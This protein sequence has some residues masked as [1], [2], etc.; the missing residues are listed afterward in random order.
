MTLRRRTFVA[1]AAAASVVAGTLPVR[2]DERMPGEIIDT[3]QHLWDLD[4]FRLPWLIKGGDIGRTFDT[5]DYLAATKGL[6]M[7][8]VYMEVDVAEDQKDLE[9]EHLIALCKQPDQPT[10][11]AVIGCRPNS[12]KF[13]EYVRRYRDV[14]VI[15]GFRQVLSSGD[16]GS[17]FIKNL[18]LLGEIDKSFDLCLPG[19]HLDA[20]VKAVDACPDTRFILDHCGNPDGKV[21]L[22][23][24]ERTDEVARILND[25]KRN[26]EALAKR[27]RVI[28][29]IS[30]IVASAPQG[31]TAE[32][33]AP[34]INHCLDSFGPK[35]VVFGSDWP[36]CLK[37][38]TLAQ[39]VAALGEVIRDR[40]AEEQ[41]AL[42]SENARRHYALG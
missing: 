12:E 34:I 30:G 33:L 10:I 28:C 39:W 20:A 27:D 21:F 40:K 31:W 9:A 18:Q 26:I 14:K 23:G 11:A 42:W 8:A 7:K 24:K 36:V 32:T 41:R 5:S 1:A 19:K 17:Q 6:N 15:K 25:W 3:H 16:F 4:K 37:G 22:T 38:A 29:K 2:A 35:R 13:G